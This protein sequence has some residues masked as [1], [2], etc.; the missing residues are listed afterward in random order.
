MRRD[1]TLGLLGALSLAGVG[2]ACGNGSSH[3]GEDA[4]ADAGGAETSVEGGADA[5]DAAVQS[6]VYPAPHHPLP[7]LVNNGGPILTAPALV[8]VTFNF[9]TA[10]DGG[11]GD[12]GQAGPDPLASTLEAFGD[13]VFSSP[14]WTAAV[15][16]YGVGPGTSGMH[17]RL[18][19]AVPFGNETISNS[20]LSD[21][22]I[23]LALQDWVAMGSLP[24]PGSETVYALYLPPTTTITTNGAVSCKQ[25]TAYHN[26]A[27][28]MV[29]GQAATVTPNYAVIARCESGQSQA[30]LVTQMTVATSRE[31][32]EGATD[33]QTE[34]MPAYYLFTNDAWVLYGDGT[35]G[36]IGDL[37]DYPG[38]TPD[39]QGSF[40]LAR[41]WSNS[42]ATASND[43]CQPAT[44]TFYGA[45]I[46]TQTI[47]NSFGDQSDGYLV[48][49]LGSTQ[50]FD[51]AVFS[52]APLPGVLSFSLGTRP[53][54]PASPGDL[55]PIGTLAGIT[56][57]LSITSGHNG[58]VASLSVT[59]ESAAPLGD[60]FIILR[61]ALSATD[62]HDWPA[63][64]HVE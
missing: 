26:A 27:M 39:M 9:A 17:V 60:T 20:N 33:P 51:V 12:G 63:I 11:A 18:P 22:Q 48:V 28:I 38:A 59:A 49:K 40:A 36:G 58:D 15:S 29:P 53:S 8:T 50:S 47:T 64:V 6:D 10:A 45:A 42:A 57:T 34:M 31:L 62:Y 23:Q 21:D 1:V 52:A 25:F 3:G 55:G 24:P 35:G 61:S 19:D 13:Q 43:P 30:A 14:W 2:V 4:G 7:T 46:D 54:M 32:A 16:S 37:C 44:D 41:V 56:A 5:A